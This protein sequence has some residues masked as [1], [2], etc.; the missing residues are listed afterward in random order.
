M[1]NK[2]AVEMKEL[3]YSHPTQEYEWKKTLQNIN[4]VK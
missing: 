3:L 2:A 4:I 1:E